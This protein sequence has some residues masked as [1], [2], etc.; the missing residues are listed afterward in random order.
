MAHS[1]LIRICSLG[2]ARNVQ[3]SI[4]NPSLVQLDWYHHCINNLWID[5]C[6]QAHGTATRQSFG[7]PLFSLSKNSSEALLYNYLCIQRHSCRTFSRTIK[8]ILYLFLFIIFSAIPAVI[9]GRKAEI[10][11]GKQIQNIY[12][13]LG[14]ILFHTKG[15]VPPLQVS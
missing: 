12:I 5:R 10:P 7:T 6:L 9:T 4:G 8:I 11:A 13:D 2:S 15:P 14:L 1:E 3:G